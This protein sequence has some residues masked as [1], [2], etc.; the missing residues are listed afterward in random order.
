MWEKAGEIAHLWHYFTHFTSLQGHFSVKMGVL[1]REWIKITVCVITGTN[2]IKELR[3]YL[4]SRV[5][6][7]LGLRNIKVGIIMNE[8]TNEVSEWVMKKKK[9]KELIDKIENLPRKAAQCSTKMPG[10]GLI[11]WKT[12]NFFSDN[13]RNS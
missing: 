9:I 2:W 11:W 5:F 1:S 10:Q 13:G 12:L 3:T 6:Y 7:L 8:W 4:R